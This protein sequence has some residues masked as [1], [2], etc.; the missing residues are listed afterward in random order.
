MSVAILTSSLHCSVAEILVSSTSYSRILR[1]RLPVLESE[2]SIL[3]LPASD[4]VQ[5][6]GQRP[7]E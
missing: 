6:G 4:T 3:S 5:G 1:E 2:I 7:R